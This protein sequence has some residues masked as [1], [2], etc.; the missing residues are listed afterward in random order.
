MVNEKIVATRPALSPVD[1]E[2]NGGDIAS[3]ARHIRNL[4]QSA[5]SDLS[6]LK[7]AVSTSTLEL[8]EWA[9]IDTFLSMIW[10]Q[11]SKVED[12]GEL[13]AEAELVGSLA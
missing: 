13:L 12:L 4:A 10:E 1:I 5:E 6:R 7:D 9:A 8:A 2:V 11:A 3:A